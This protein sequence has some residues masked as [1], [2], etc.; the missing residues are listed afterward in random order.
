MKKLLVEILFYVIAAAI[1]LPT[2]T[3]VLAH[4]TGLSW[5]QVLYR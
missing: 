4:M 1:I 3:L 5:Q 2:P